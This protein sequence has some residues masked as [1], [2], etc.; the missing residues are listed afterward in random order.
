[1]TQAQKAKLI[2]VSFPPQVPVPDGDVLRGE[3]QG[4]NAWDY[5]LLLQGDA[6]AVAQWY[7]QAYQRAEWT[8]TSDANNTIA[9]EKNSAQSKVVLEAGR[10]K[11]GSAGAQ[12]TTRATVTLGIGTPVLQ[13][14]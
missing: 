10:P 8:I 9:F 6:A 2:A 7:R 1:M 5:Q 11:S 4:A 3:A 13:T 14:Q 12:P